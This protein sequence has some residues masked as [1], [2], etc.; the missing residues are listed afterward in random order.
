MS[1]PRK[2]PG[3]AVCIGCGCDDNHACAGAVGEPCHWVRIDRDA[4]IG[5]CSE[6]IEHSQRWDRGDRQF[7]VPVEAIREAVP[8]G[9]MAQASDPRLAAAKSKILTALQNGPIQRSE[10]SWSVLDNKFRAAQA[11]ALVDELLA[12]GL[13]V[14]FDQVVHRP[15]RSR[16]VRMVRL[17]EAR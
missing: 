15:H 12:D 14:E 1:R 4:G 2:P 3:L 9:P 7:A 6:C 11:K 16:E 5:L 13:V 17:V 10:L 8:R